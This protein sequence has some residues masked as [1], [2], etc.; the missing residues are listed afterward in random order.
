MKMRA[1]KGRYWVEWRWKCLDYGG[2]VCG[3]DGRRPPFSV[4]I[5]LSG[6]AEP[7]SATPSRPVNESFP[8]VLEVV[9]GASWCQS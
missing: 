7:K 9:Y 8:K 3:V 5:S 2:D 4:V 1:R 6:L